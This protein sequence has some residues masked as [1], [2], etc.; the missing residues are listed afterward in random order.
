MASRTRSQVRARLRI[1]FFDSKRVRRSVDRTKRRSLSGGGAFVRTT[2][3]RSMRRRRRP[4]Q[5]GKPPTVREGSLKRLIFFGWDRRSE[6]VVVGPL[7]IKRSPVP[8]VLEFGG[9]IPSKRRRGKFGR[10]RGRVRIKAR[11]F[12]GPALSKALERR[13]LPKQFKNSVRGA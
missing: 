13:V 10:R 1:D 4:S 9:T 11:P 5:P 7:P 2:A 3:K 12:M 8:N 6:T